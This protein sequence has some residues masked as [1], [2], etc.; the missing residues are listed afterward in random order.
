MSG[1]SAG[2]RGV[3]PGEVPPACWDC[4][5]CGIGSECFCATPNRVLGYGCESVE[6]SG[7]FCSLPAGHEGEHEAWALPE[8]GTF[9]AASE[10]LTKWPA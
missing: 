10:M 9:D 6:G 1:Y 3:R 2:V 8:G 7:L 5:S 4:I